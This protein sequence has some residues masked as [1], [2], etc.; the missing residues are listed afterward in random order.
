MPQRP[1][2]VQRLDLDDDYYYIVPFTRGGVL[3]ARLMIDAR[4]NRFV[5]ATG[6]ET[7]GQRLP[8]Y[9]DP[10][11][12]LE[13]SY[14]RVIDLPH[15]RKRIIRPGTVGLHPVLVWKPSAESSSPWLPFYQLSVGD[16]FVYLRVD[17]RLT[18]RLRTG[19]V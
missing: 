12:L 14:G 10:V 16:E 11:R 13:E 1:L 18:D 9:I 7:A 19:P 3:T 2:T 4:E 15:V 5:E 8:P 6:I 17:G